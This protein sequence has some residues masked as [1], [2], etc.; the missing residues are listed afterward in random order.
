MTNQ[1]IIMTDDGFGE[2]ANG[3]KNEG[4]KYAQLCVKV[5][6]E[7]YGADEDTINQTDIL[8]MAIGYLIGSS[9][10][11]TEPMPPEDLIKDR[12]ISRSD[13]GLAKWGLTRKQYNQN[14]RNCES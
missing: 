3:I 7:N 10:K 11:L 2:W 14:R 1:S 12:L 9:V 6:V 8:E 13:Y 4:A 5:L